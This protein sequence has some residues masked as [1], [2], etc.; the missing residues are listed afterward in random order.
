LQGRVN[1][2]FRLIAF[3]F[4]PLGAALSGVLIEQL[5]VY[6]ALGLFAAVLLGLA[7]MTTLNSHVRNARP[8]AGMAE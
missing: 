6:W 3:G 4:Q 7:I 1:S 8:I 2:T 5:N